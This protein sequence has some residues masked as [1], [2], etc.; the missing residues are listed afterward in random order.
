M[1]SYDREAFAYH[2]SAKLARLGLS[3]RAAADEWP[4]TNAA[5]WSRIKNGKE[6]SA[7]NLLLVCKLLKLAPM[8]YLIRDKRKRVTMKAIG[9]SLLRQAV[10]DS[11]SRGTAEFS[12]TSN[13]EQM[14]CVH[15]STPK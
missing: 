13:K 2:V 9:K 6:V 12:T 10:T 3:G 8:R 5:L 14:P 11:V 4:E 1:A 7:G 15:S